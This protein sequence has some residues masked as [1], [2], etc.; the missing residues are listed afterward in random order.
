MKKLRNGPGFEHIKNKGKILVGIR[1]CWAEPWA[2]LCPQLALQM[3]FFSP[4]LALRHR[5]SQTSHSRALCQHFQNFLHVPC[6]LWREIFPVRKGKYA[7]LRLR[8]GRRWRGRRWSHVRAPHRLTCSSALQVTVCDFPGKKRR[9]FNTLHAL[10]SK[11]L[12]LGCYRR[13][14][15]SKK[16]APGDGESQR[17]IAAQ[18]P[19]DGRGVSPHAEPKHLAGSG[20]DV[21]THLFLPTAA[22]PCP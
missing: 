17:S 10:S 3:G 9:I 19:M 8:A 15:S 13:S 5:S 1:R 6:S 4:L 2:T 11:S 22:F 20:Q 16:Q 21:R 7:Q 18:H 12:M 14:R